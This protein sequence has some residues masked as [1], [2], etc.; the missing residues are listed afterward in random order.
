MPCDCLEETRIS[1]KLIKNDRWFG[2]STR[3]NILRSSI[4]IHLF[5]Q[6]PFCLK[7]N[8]NM[9]PF[10]AVLTY[11]VFIFEIKVIDSK[12]HP[13]W[14]GNFDESSSKRCYISK[15]TEIYEHHILSFFN[16]RQSRDLLREVVKIYSRQMPVAK[17]QISTES[18]FHFFP[19]N[20]PNMRL[21]IFRLLCVLVSNLQRAFLF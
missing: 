10:W 16:E 2:P 5:K 11:G 7:I 13:L 6:L 15:D 9:I 20:W 3:A 4:I 8:I 18:V 17:C 21:N 1:Y 12:V 14:K 19:L